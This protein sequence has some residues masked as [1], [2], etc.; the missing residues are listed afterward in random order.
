MQK[1]HKLDAQ[2]KE[3][4]KEVAK[5]PKVV[6]KVRPATPPPPPSPPP[7]GNSLK[8]MIWEIGPLLTGTQNS[9]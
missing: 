6:E 3:L 7:P 1:C 5:G 8:W 2:I 4:Q 9:L